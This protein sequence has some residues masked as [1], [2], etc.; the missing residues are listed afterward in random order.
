MC[1]CCCALLLGARKVALPP[2]RRK[3]L[4]EEEVSPTLAMYK[5]MGGRYVNLPSLFATAGVHSSLQ[6]GRRHV[7]RGLVMSD[8]FTLVAFF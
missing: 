8:E 7:W 3:R 4:V 2:R 5:H 1:R 6:L